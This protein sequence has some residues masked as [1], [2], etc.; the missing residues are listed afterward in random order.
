MIFCIIFVDAF[1]L[2][3]LSTI[4]IPLI[5]LTMALNELKI[6]DSRKV[7]F[8]DTY[9]VCDSGEPPQG[10]PRHSLYRHKA[11]RYFRSCNPVYAFRNKIEVVKY[12]LSSYAAISWDYV[13]VR[14]ELE[15]ESQCQEFH[16]FCLSLFPNADIQPERSDT[17]LKYYN[18]LE[19]LSHLGNP[20]IFFAPNNDHPFL[21]HPVVFDLTVN[22]ASEID[23]LLGPNHDLIIPYSHFQEFHRS[24]SPLRPLWGYYGSNF[25]STRLETQWGFLA[26]SS[27]YLIDAISLFRLNHLLSIFGNTKKSGRLI[28]TEDTEFYLQNQELFLFIPKHELCRHFDSY[29]GFQMANVV[30]PLCIPPGFFENRINISYSIVRNDSALTVNPL[31]NAFSDSPSRPDLSSYLTEVPFFW[32]KYVSS[33]TINP[34]VIGEFA[35]RLSTSSVF[36]SMLHAYVGHRIFDVSPIIRAIALLRYLRRRSVLASRAIMLWFKCLFKRFLFRRAS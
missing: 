36:S 16:D 12:T 17:A 11:I 2:P 5:S 3:L 27:R 4:F 29:S 22:S 13:L 10:D 35:Y 18:K 15:D 31:V 6:G 30:H 32:H 25:I 21:A 24:S 23:Y 9:I 26:S 19:K 1:F 7:L 33:L 34:D 8:F 28:R 20:W 14:Y